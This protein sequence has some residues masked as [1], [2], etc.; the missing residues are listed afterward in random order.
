MC[1]WGKGRCA[2]CVDPPTCDCFVSPTDGQEIAGPSGQEVA[3]PSGQA[4]PS[5]GQQAAEESQEGQESPG[6]GSGHTSP[7][8]EVEGE[9]DEGVEDEDTDIAREVLLASDL[10]TL[11]ATPEAG[12]SQATIRGSPS[13]SSPNRPPPQW[14]LSP[15]LPGHKPQ[16][17]AGRRPRRPGGWPRFC[18]PVCGGTMPSDPPSGSDQ[19]DSGPDGQPGLN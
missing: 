14:S 15:L 4:A 9:E 5:P 13:H 8:E 6:E 12:S 17:Q 19:P 10:L 1:G 7:H 3:G 2:K 11:E 18:R 16:L